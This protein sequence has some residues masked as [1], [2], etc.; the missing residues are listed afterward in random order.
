MVHV[1]K[2]KR[3]GAMV[4]PSLFTLGNLAFGF[5]ALVSVSDREYARAAWLVLGGMVMDGLDGKVARIVH[6]ESAFGVELDSLA[7]FLTFCITPAFLM[8]DLLLKDIPIWGG[9][10]AFLYALCG[11]LRLARFNVA[12][13]MAGG[14]SGPYFS[15]LPTPAAAGILSSFVLLYDILETDRPAHTLRAVMEGLPYLYAAFPF[16]MVA[17]SFLMVSKVPYRAFKQPL[18]PRSLRALITL[19]VA[20]FFIYAYPQNAIFLF[21]LFYLLSGVLGALFSGARSVRTAIATRQP[22]TV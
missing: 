13:Q 11:G 8:Y 1:E 14:G 5:F 4:L 20:G 9:A 2:L 15:G 21:F 7:D 22:P 18:R 3:H 10:V 16:V 6:G 19:V 12:A 17:V